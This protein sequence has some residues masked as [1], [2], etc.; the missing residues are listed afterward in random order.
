M[1]TKKKML[2]LLSLLPFFIACGD[3]NTDIPDWPWAE[4]ETPTEPVEANPD[5][6]N[7]GWANVKSTYGTLPE[8]INVYKS[9]ET[10]E[11]KKAI[12]YIAVGD[13]SKA[14]FGVLGEK[15]GLKKPKE[16]Y[17]ENNSTIVINGGFFYEGSLSLIWRN[18][19]MV[20]KNNDVTAED[21]TNG[22]FWYPVL[23]AFCEMNDGSF[24]SMWTYTT[25]SNVT[26]WYSE[27]SPVKSETTPNENGMYDGFIFNV[28][29]VKYISVIGIFKDPRQLEQYS[30]CNSE[31]YLNLS[32]ISNEVKK[33]LTEKKLR[34]YKA[35]LTPVTP[36]TQEP[37]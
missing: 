32:S 12:A 3:D 18:G 14:A 21:W 24:K 11:G 29:F 9:P 19:E 10:L 28:P 1:S 20:C 8:H 35:F 33:R 22:P 4:P 27:P 34:Y 7:L 6:V 17:E 31:H 13:M 23:A 26:Y 30:C 36:N 16:F 25:L 15:T 2:W 5:I 37:K